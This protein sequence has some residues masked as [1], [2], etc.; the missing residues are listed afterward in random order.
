MCDG[1][2]DLE[3]VFSL[4]DLPVPEENENG[5]FDSIGGLITQ[6]IGRIPDIGEQ[7]ELRYGGLRL[8]VMQVG[9]RRILKVLCSRDGEGE[10]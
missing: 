2:C 7:I 3:D 9:E 8:K 4:F 6:Q 10:E 1:L 5:D